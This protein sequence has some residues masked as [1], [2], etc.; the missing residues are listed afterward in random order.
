MK[1]R[2]LRQRSIV[3]IC[4]CAMALA[5][6]LL[7][8]ALSF[9]IPFSSILMMVFLPMF[10]ALVAV[11]TRYQ[12]QLALIIA[13]ALCCFIDIQDGFFYLLPNAVIG[14]VYGDLLKNKVSVLFAFV[15]AF[16]A[17]SLLNTLSYF[18]IKFLFNVDMIQVFAGILNIERSVFLDI[19]PL[20]SMITA[21]ISTLLLF[22]IS[23]EDLKKFGV[24]LNTLID[25]NVVA[26]FSLILMS[27]SMV[28]GVNDLVMASTIV[29]GLS[30]LPSAITIINLV[31]DL[32]GYK[33]VILYVLFTVSIGLFFVP[34]SI[35]R[36]LSYLG[37]NF[38]LFLFPLYSLL[39]DSVKK[40]EKTLSLKGGSVGKDEEIDL[41]ASLGQ[42]CNNFSDNVR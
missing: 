14:L 8:L 27:I 13:I 39:L 30:F 16:I 29:L 1:K 33:A 11:K 38:L 15:G 21:S 4:Y 9:V 17:A 18:P 36:S 37:F 22:V 12:Y 10:L 19:Y 40:N 6:C 41:L 31:E 35:D 24:E 32:R 20:F 25:R 7:F 3:E 42:S 26:L 5:I 34:F 28:L 2:A 23:S